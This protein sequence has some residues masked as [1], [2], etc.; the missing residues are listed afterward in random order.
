MN[1][2]VPHGEVTVSGPGKIATFYVTEPRDV[3]IEPMELNDF[4]WDVV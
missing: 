1:A 2:Y 4:H 3:K